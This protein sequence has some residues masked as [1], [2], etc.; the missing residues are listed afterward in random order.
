MSVRP[1]LC[2]FTD[3]RP[4]DA[5]ALVLPADERCGQEVA[6]HEEQQEDVV[7]PAVIVRVGN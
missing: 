1:S 6:A 4:T 2:L 7:Q 5:E 3:W